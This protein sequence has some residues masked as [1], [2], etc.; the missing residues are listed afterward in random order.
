MYL[1]TLNFIFTYIC[2]TKYQNG[3]Q[4]KLQIK[5]LSISNIY[6]WQKVGKQSMKIFSANRK[7]KTQNGKLTKAYCISQGS[8]G[9]KGDLEFK[10]WTTYKGKVR[11]QEIS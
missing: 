1:V 5:Q 8:V 10:T 7:E 9:T 6:N 11:T 4:N 3:V 2:T